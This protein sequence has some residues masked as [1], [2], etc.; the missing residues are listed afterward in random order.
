MAGRLGLSSSC[1]LLELR[2]SGHSVVWPS[3]ANLPLAGLK[4]PWKNGVPMVTQPSPPS[5]ARL[6]LGR[7]QYHQSP[8]PPIS[9]VGRESGRGYSV[10]TVHSP[11][12]IQ[13]E[14]VVDTLCG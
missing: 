9:F 13:V 14:E 5:R 7:G 11:F 10:P 8:C 1:S 4:K 12:T 6:T 3:I 2:F